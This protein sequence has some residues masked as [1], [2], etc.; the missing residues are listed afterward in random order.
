MAY[1]FPS[2]WD[3]ESRNEL[4]KM[5]SKLESLPKSTDEVWD[6]ITEQIQNIEANGT[7]YA[8]KG[9]VFPFEN[10]GT[11]ENTRF[12]SG[13]LDIKVYHAEEGAIYRVSHVSKDNTTWGAAVT[14]F[15][16]GKSVDDGATWE[17]LTSRGNLTLPNDQSGVKTHTLTLSNIDEIFVLAVDWNS[18]TT[19]SNN[20][21]IYDYIISPLN[22][23]Y[24]PRE[25]EQIKQ[26]GYMDN[27][28]LVYPLQDLGGTENA[29]FKNAILDVKVHYADPNAIY[30]ISHISKDNTAWGSPLTFIELGK[31][32]DNGATWIVFNAR[33]GVSLP[34]DQTYVQTHVINPNNHDEIVTVTLNWN[35]LVT[36]SNNLSASNYIIHPSLYFFRRSSKSGVVNDLGDN[37]VAKKEDR[38]IMIKQRYDDTRN[39][40]IE[41]NSVGINNFHEFR[42][43]YL[44]DNTANDS[45][46]S[47]I[48]VAKSGTD[49]ISPYGMLVVN[50][51]VGSSAGSV[52]VGGS[53]GTE[54]NTGFPTGEFIQLSRFD[55]DGTPITTMPLRGK[56]LEL[57]AEH[58][59]SASNAVSK[60]TGVKR[61]TAIERRM[62]TITSQNHNVTVEIE[63][64]EDITMT[65]YAGFMMPMVSAF[66]D[67]FYLYDTGGEIGLFRS[68]G[69]PE[70][71]PD[72]IYH[73]ENK[74][75]QAIDRAVLVND[76][77]LL[78]MITDRTFGIGTGEHAPASTPDKPQSPILYTGGQF[79]KI[80][81]HN[82]G[83]SSNEYLVK[84]GDKISYRGGYH[85]VDYT[86]PQE[87]VF[88]YEINGVAQLDDLR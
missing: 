34:N 71:L 3:R 57:T 53:H 82:L 40:I 67:Y 83:G 33:G 36:G 79:G 32:Y 65:R 61:N 17:V 9:Q 22:Y 6:A 88:E 74:D 14:Y 69:L 25:E 48:E 7:I 85:F 58:Y 86:Q 24:V 19:G 8:N 41:Y 45:D 13:F 37:I 62:Y 51:P 64:L 12:N 46:F 16:I 11:T 66:F 56:T 35:S 5:S 26:P 47:G 55:L 63:A 44:Q 42:G 68:G 52:T 75:Y 28:G 49:W 81:A 10:R 38:K 78:V 77:M 30:R 60:L 4:N 15:E 84:A 87:N 21:G 80:S 29:R 20:L 2:I 76:D 43:F 39:F 72:G 73:T 18:F 23:I 1:I 31:S 54:S 27:A 59:V 50:N 70:G